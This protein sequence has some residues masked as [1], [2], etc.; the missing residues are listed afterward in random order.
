VGVFTMITL[1]CGLLKGDAVSFA[2]EKQP[3]HQ[4]RNGCRH[5]R[6]LHP[7]TPRV[8][9]PIVTENQSSWSSF[10]LVVEIHGINTVGF[11]SCPH[12]SIAPN[13]S[14]MDVSSLDGRT[15]TIFHIPNDSRK[16]VSVRGTLMGW[17][18]ANVKP[19]KKPKK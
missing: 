7:P 11:R 4:P 1:C 16:C 5:L 9:H 2:V 15:K 12:T 10:I 14:P 19:Q 8:A 13:S 17:I 18:E 6:L 3:S